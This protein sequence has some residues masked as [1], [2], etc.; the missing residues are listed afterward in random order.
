MAG[1]FYATGDAEAAKVW[2]RLLSVEM[3]KSTYFGKF[4]DDSGDEESN[5]LFIQK[6]DLERSHGDRVTCYLRMQGTGRGKIEHETLEGAEEA[7]Q[8]YADNVT[9]NKIRHAFKSED[10]ISPQRVTF[11]L[12]MQA[13]NALRDWFADRLDT[14]MANQLAGNTA[15]TDVAYTGLQ[16]AVAPDAAH[17]I[18]GG[19]QAN[20]ES[21]GSSHKIKLSHIDVL[22]N[23]ARTASAGGVPIRPIRLKGKEYYVLF[24][25]P[26]QETDLRTDAS[27]AGNWFDLQKA[28]LQGGEGDGN[29]IFDGAMGMYNNTVIHTWDR[30]PNGVHS[31]TGAA[32]PNTR[33]AVFCGAGAALVAFGQS[34]GRARVSWTEKTFDYDDYFGV[35]ARLVGG[36]KK[37]VYNSTDFATIVLSTYAATPTPA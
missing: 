13:K 23:R 5:S 4:L 33:R 20:D 37:S 3:L 11:D 14:W 25:H 32:F 16:A 18:R 19:N 26:D 6:T 27:T 15:Q 30:L 36:I 10:V 35:S 12:R 29:G 8:T 24:I 17:I 2:S 28:R 21:L 1:K 31:S 34:Y 22:R 7:I 9:I